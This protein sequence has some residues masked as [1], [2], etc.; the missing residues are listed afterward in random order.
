MK[1]TQ[2]PTTAMEEMQLNAGVLLSSFTPST[3]E[4]TGIIGATTEIGRAHV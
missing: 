1:F 4:V 2:I 3:A